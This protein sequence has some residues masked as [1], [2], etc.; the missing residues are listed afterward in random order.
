MPQLRRNAELETNMELA[1]QTAKREKRN[2]KSA[3]TRL[4][5]TLTTRLSDRR[6]KKEDIIEA[7]VIKRCESYRRR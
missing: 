2:A 7:W 4:L 6:A 3:L 5:S 1:L